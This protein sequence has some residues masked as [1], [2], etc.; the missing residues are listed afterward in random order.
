MIVQHRVVARH[1]GREQR[2]RKWEGVRPAP[3]HPVEDADEHD[4]VERDERELAD[5]GDGVQQ[6]G[7]GAAPGGTGSRATHY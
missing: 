4:A 1:N 7:V 2:C 3:A 6:Q 5:A